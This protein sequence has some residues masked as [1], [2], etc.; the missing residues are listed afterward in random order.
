MERCRPKPWT[1]RKPEIASG[2]ARPRV[3]TPAIPRPCR[4]PSQLCF[5]KHQDSCRRH[6]SALIAHHLHSPNEL[7]EG[8]RAGGR[9]AADGSPLLRAGPPVPITHPALQL[10]PPGAGRPLI[11][12]APLPAPA[13]TRGRRRPPRAY[14]HRAPRTKGALGTLA[15]FTCGHLLPRLRAPSAK[16]ASG[17][18]EG[19]NFCSTLLLE[20]C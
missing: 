18:R 10:L 16:P 5:S 19:V 9:P 12:P 6:A 13:A 20:I 7:G 3:E 2:R 11:H 14:L 4:I 1:E 17:P 15:S 8:G